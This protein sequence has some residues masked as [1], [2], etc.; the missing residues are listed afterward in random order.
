LRGGRL[1][2]PVVIR[3]SFVAAPVGFF[4]IQ[5]HGSSSMN[6]PDSRI[7]HTLEILAPA[8]R[9]D[10][11]VVVV[12]VVVVR[13]LLVRCCS[14]S[15]PLSLTLFHWLMRGGVDGSRNA[16]RAVPRA[17]HPSILL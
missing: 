17:R 8:H 3:G 6:F 4:G 15:R 16:R 2:N 13:R 14:L 1:D 12:V 10:V 5:E 9:T 11:V 7:H